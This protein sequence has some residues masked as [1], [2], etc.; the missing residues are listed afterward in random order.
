MSKQCD[1]NLQLLS[2]EVGVEVELAGEQNQVQGS[3]VHGVEEH[4][5][6][7]R[8]EAPPQLR[9]VVV[10]LVVSRHHA[11]GHLQNNNVELFS[12]SPHNR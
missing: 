6:R 5:G 11:I 12:F 4:R 8:T 7:G 1:L 9:E 3:H 10:A 2:A